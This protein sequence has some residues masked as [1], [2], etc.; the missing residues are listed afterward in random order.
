MELGRQFTVTIKLNSDDFID[1][2][3]RPEEM[4]KVSARL[5]EEGMDAIEISGGSSLSVSKYT[6]Y[7]IMESDFQEE[8]IYYRDAARLYKESLTIPLILVGGIRTFEIARKLIEKEET[9]YVSL[10][11]PLI[12]EPDLIKRWQSGDA[13][14]ASCI[15]CNR[16]F[17]PSRAGEGLYCVLDK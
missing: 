13:R 7:R 2:G 6:S 14:R 17:I 4:V 15:S 8:E 5:E 1:G 11:R 9:D 3:F 10:S 16:C 12:R